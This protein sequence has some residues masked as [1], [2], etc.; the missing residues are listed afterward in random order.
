MATTNVAYIG[1][2]TSL[3]SNYYM[4]NFYIS[5]RDAATSSKRSRMTNAELSLADGKALRQAVKKLGNF[6]FDETQDENIRSGVLAYLNT[7]N[8]MLTS[9]SDSSDRE[10]LRDMKR[11]K[12]VT[13]EYASELDKIGITVNENGSLT[14]RDALFTTASLS[15][16]ESLFSKDAEY[17]QRTTSCSKRIEKRANELDLTRKM[18]ERLKKESVPSPDTPGNESNSYA[19]DTAIP[20]AASLD[21]DLLLNTGVGKNINLVL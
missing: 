4:R 8:N 21:L 2:G 19:M 9:L 14:S 10:L 15:K 17:M 11:L 6:S 5:N 7:Y 18:Q 1:T 3:S 13:S 12:S 16:F 20:A